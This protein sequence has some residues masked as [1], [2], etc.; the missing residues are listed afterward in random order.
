MRTATTTTMPHSP[1]PSFKR[2]Y[3]SVSDLVE[4]YGFTERDLRRMRLKKIG[5]PFRY[6][7]GSR[8]KPMYE[9]GALERWIESRNG[10]GEVFRN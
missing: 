8:Q 9:V 2:R 5:P 7:H 4:Q 10:G 6:F 1:L 3:L